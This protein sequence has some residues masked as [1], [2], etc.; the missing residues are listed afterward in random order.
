[1]RFWVNFGSLWRPKVVPRMDQKSDFF[2]TCR[3]K[4]SPGG[5]KVL[6]G[7]ILATF[8][9]H[10][11]GIWRSLGAILLA[12]WIQKWRKETA[13]RSNWPFSSQQQKITANSGKPQ[14]TAANRSKWQQKDSKCDQTAANIRKDSQQKQT[15]ANSNMWQRTAAN[16]SN[17]QQASANI[18][19]WQQTA[20]TASS[21]QQRQIVTNRSKQQLTAANTGVRLQTAADK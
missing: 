1:M 8:W 6:Q 17:P 14:Q 15:G 16:S 13:N 2:E 7:A 18:S 9:A 20:K 5:P 21:N 12:F 3:L 19:K 4:G 10:L 11:G